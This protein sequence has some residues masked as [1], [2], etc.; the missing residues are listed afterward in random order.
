MY[1]L[2]TFWF[3]FITI[4][5]YDKV[6]TNPTYTQV[7]R[8]SILFQLSK[9]CQKIVKKG[10]KAG[11]THPPGQFTK[12]GPNLVFLATCTPP[13]IKVGSIYE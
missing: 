11:F 9:N 4:Y 6:K 10:F 2:G 1:I 7:N 8:H 12:N 13:E 5:V 3:V